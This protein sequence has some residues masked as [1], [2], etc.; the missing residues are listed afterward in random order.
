VK[1]KAFA[2]DSLA[3]QF[4]RP[5]T[6]FDS[7]FDPNDDEPLRS[8]RSPTPEEVKKLWRDRPR[9]TQR[10]STIRSD[11]NDGVEIRD[12][13]CLRCAGEVS[14]FP[15]LQCWTSPNSIAGKCGD[16]VRKHGFCYEVSSILESYFKSWNRSLGSLATHECFANDPLDS[17]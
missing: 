9:N 6:D 11:I 3:N 10:A 13:P 7:D 1:L 14:D 8:M 5:A 15:H 4:I 16:C 2:G 17:C 12:I